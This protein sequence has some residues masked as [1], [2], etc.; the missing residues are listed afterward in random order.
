MGSA[1][2][3]TV[4]PLQ[5][6]WI[7]TGGP[8]PPGAD[9]IVPVEATEAVGDWVRLRE[10][11]RPGDNVLSRGADVRAGQVVLPAGHRL[12][13][14][15]VGALASVGCT[16][17][18]VYRRPEVAILSMGDE[19][20][21]PDRIPAEGQ[22][23]DANAYSLA[24]AVRA[25]GGIPHVLG[26]VPDDKNRL[27]N[28]LR[29]ALQW[30]M[31]LMSGGSS[32]GLDDVA[33]EVIAKLGPPGVVVHGVRLAPGKPTVLAVV[34]DRAVCGLPGNPVSSLVAYDL[35]VRPAL[36][37]RMGW[38]GGRPPATVRARLA[39]P[40]AAPKGREFHARVRLVA[41]PEGLVAQP[42]AGGSGQLAT[43][44]RADG[45]VTVPLERSSLPAGETVE[46]R[47]LV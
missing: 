6:V 24:A 13:A 33:A 47:L 14:A 27:E 29:D 32:V 45:L 40:L 5:A 20:V 39:E 2:K 26:I 23:R 16:R 12:R 25:D 31:V 44:A 42:V 38:P 41:G 37:W 30:D 46:V 1:P 11:V 10:P 36:Y 43:M 9:A 15:D 34:G 4:G 35:F 21:P 3:A 19:L 28:A 7:P 8:L 17:P 18:W 22:V